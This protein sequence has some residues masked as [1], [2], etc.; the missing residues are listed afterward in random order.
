MTEKF[1]AKATKQRNEE[2]GGNE[3]PS[4]KVS[5]PTEETVLGIPPWKGIFD[6]IFIKA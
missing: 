4:H 6:Q 3:S 5:S 2:T 1:E